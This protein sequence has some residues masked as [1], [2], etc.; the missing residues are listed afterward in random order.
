MLTLPIA[1]GLWVLLQ[2]DRLAGGASRRYVKISLL[3]RITDES[4]YLYYNVPALADLLPHLEVVWLLILVE[5]CC[6]SCELLKLCEK[7]IP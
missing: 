7:L 3:I 6:Q 5:R 4:F 1:S 2:L